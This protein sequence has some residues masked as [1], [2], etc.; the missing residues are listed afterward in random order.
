M[1]PHRLF[2]LIKFLYLHCALPAPLQKC[3]KMVP[4][5]Y[6]SRSRSPQLGFEV[7]NWR[8]KRNFGGTDW[9]VH[10]FLSCLF[11]FCSVLFFNTGQR[12]KCTESKIICSNET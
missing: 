5:M 1:E 6:R 4:A 12:T 2:F 10:F 3:P 9:D 11:V 8:L 7:A